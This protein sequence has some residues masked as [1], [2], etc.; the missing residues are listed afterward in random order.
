MC[1]CIGGWAFFF[2]ANVGE[3]G[4][5]SCAHAKEGGGGGG[6]E[7]VFMCAQKNLL[8]FLFYNLKKR[9]PAKIYWKKW[10]LPRRGGGESHVHKRIFM[11]MCIAEWSLFPYAYEGGIFHVPM[12]GDGGVGRVFMCTKIVIEKKKKNLRR[13]RKFQLIVKKRGPP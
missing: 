1:M 8:I 9:G 7:G 13:E 5:F 6:V 12:R 3:G 11:C 4:S 2:Y 10:G